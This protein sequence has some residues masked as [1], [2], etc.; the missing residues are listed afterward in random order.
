M[1]WLERSP[2]NVLSKIIEKI[3]YVKT[4]ERHCLGVFSCMDIPCTGLFRAKNGG[5]SII[6]QW[7]YK[8]KIHALFLYVLYKGITLTFLKKNGT[9]KEKWIGAIYH[10]M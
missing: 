5:G 7:E 6:L 2:R 3:I 10:E 8:V 9:I 1:P 4:L